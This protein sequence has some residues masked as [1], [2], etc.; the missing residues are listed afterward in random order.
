MKKVNIAQAKQGLSR[1]VD[2]ARRGERILICRRNEP[3]AELRAIEAGP[4]RRR[5]IG[6]AAGR[7]VVPDDFDAPLPEVELAA[8]SGPPSED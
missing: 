6:L 3:V 4:V 2:R 7:F 1:L 8:W 5:P